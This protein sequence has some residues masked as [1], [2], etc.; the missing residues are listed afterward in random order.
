MNIPQ[1]W[2]KILDNNDEL[3]EMFAE[4][5]EMD[6]V[7]L[8]PPFFFHYFRPDNYELLKEYFVGF[9]NG[10]TMYENVKEIFEATKDNYIHEDTVMAYFIPKNKEVSEENLMKLS[11][12]YIE[13]SNYILEENK[14]QKYD[15]TQLEIRKMTEDEFEKKFDYYD[16]DEC[17]LHDLIGDWMRDELP[18]EDDCPLVLFYEALYQIACDY[19]ISHYILWPL[20]GIDNKNPF[21][22]YIKLWKFG[23]TPRIVSD[24]LMV[25]VK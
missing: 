8:V 24:K 16:I 22:A 18:D 12:E 10:M 9:K 13:Q 3:K 6:E 25:L 7:E 1:Q 21:S 11:Q 17:E 14:E 5:N 23:Y 19:N 20:L 2:I 15:F 4:Q